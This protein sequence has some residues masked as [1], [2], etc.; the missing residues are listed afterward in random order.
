[1]IQMD[2]SFM[3]ILRKKEESRFTRNELSDGKRKLLDS[4]PS[5]KVE[6]PEYS[7]PDNKEE[8]SEVIRIMKEKKISESEMED[9]D[10]NNNELMLG[11][12]DQKKN[13][14]IELIKDIDIYTIRLKMKYTRPRPYEI[15]K[16]IESTT[17]T[18]DSPSFPSGHAIEA[19]ALAVI[20]GDKFPEKKEELTKMADRISLSRLQMGNHYPSDI[21][22]GEKV[23]K[24]IADTYLGVKKSYTISKSEKKEISEL[25]T[26]LE[27]KNLGDTAAL[28]RVLDIYSKN[29]DLRDARI[30]KPLQKF[31]DT[32]DTRINEITK[33]VRGLKSKSGFEKLRKKFGGRYFQAFAKYGKGRTDKNAP[34]FDIRTYNGKKA[35]TVYIELVQE[36]PGLSGAGGKVSRT[37]Y[38][39]IMRYMEA[40]LDNS[41]SLSK[42]RTELN[43]AISGLKGDAELETKVA[44]FN[45]IKDDLLDVFT[46]MA[47]EVADFQEF[48]KEAKLNNAEDAVKIGDVALGGLGVKGL[49]GFADL[50]GNLYDSVDYLHDAYFYVEDF[51]D[52]LRTS[53]ESGTKDIQEETGISAE[54]LDMMQNRPGMELKLPKQTKEKD[55]EKDN[56][57]V[58]QYTKTLVE[59]KKMFS[60]MDRLVDDFDGHQ[61]EI[62]DDKIL[63]SFDKKAK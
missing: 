31:I 39:R 29:N 43:E 27:E 25:L 5:F 34:V 54:L 15:S 38:T 56:E 50:S 10:R 11:I 57:T 14:W 17:D 51:I 40:I 6:F 26:S 49:K 24:L 20:L 58:V 7:F 62:G 4:E 32:F 44:T 36:I 18:D 2:G 42:S 16:E 47:I 61:F 8:L 30:R 48:D 45:K 41:L 22:V 13:D 59:A 55:D 9:L 35:D 37:K 33:L 52:A 21:E 28:V 23:G 60:T 53:E 12:V 19:H 63:V 46:E 1:M 3:D